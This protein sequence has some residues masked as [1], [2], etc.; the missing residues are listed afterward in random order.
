M[1]D[2]PSDRDDDGFLTSD[3]VK[4]GYIRGI[5]DM[6]GFIVE[7][8][9]YTEVDGQAV[10]EGCILLGSAEEMANLTAEVEASP[11]LDFLQQ[12]EG[13]GLTVLP[14]YLWHKGIMPYVIDDNLPAKD[15]VTDAISHWTS[16]TGIQF[17]VR[18][19]QSD[20]VAFV[21]ANGCAANVGRQGGKQ[22]VKLGSGCTLGN[23][24][25]EIGHALGLWHE[26]GRSDRDTYI[27]VKLE[28]VQDSALH[29]FTQHLH[30]GID[31]GKYDFGSIMHYGSHFFT[32]NGQPTIV[33]KN[34]EAIGQ[35]EALSAG[36][37]AAIQEAYKAEFA[38]R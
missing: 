35:R 5:K 27:A 10:F 33:T 1:T 38:K 15:R 11:G 31:R 14:R 24:V 34:G 17:V 16:K 28:N 7:P 23:T 21:P 19:D 18:T 29:N 12:G 36:D 25:H 22:F 20:Y 30:D 2:L 32:K 9:T 4:Q 8:V 26:Q 6:D 37:I 3:T 13:F